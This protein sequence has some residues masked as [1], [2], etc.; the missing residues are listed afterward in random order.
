M[1]A[2]EFVNGEPVS[3]TFNALQTI[4]ITPQVSESLAP[5]ISI[6]AVAFDVTRNPSAP[7]FQIGGQV[8]LYGGFLQPP[9]G[10][11][12]TIARYDW[13]FGNGATKTVGVNETSLNPLENPATA[14]YTQP[15][16][17]PVTL[18]LVTENSTS[19]AS[20]RTSVEQTVAV[21]SSSQP[22]A[23]FLYSGVVP[24][25]TVINIADNSG[26]QYTLDPD[27]DWSACVEV[28]DNIFSTLLIYNGSSTTNFIPMAASEVPSVSNGGI[29]PDYT[30]YTFH[31][32]SGLKF[33]NGDP[34]TAYDVY[35]SIVRALL[36]RG[37][38]GSRWKWTS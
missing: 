34:L 21:G 6:P 32:R 18:T 19:M 22:Y 24:N 17:Y 11:N 27:L 5:L 8:Y 7:V 16:L 10:T 14:T 31:I 20:F 26:P 2:Q 35:Y 9:T 29:S 37:S 25:P 36:F 12:V 38:T 4:Q 1:A 33:S 3:S 30:S 15:G 23:L 28:C 13:D